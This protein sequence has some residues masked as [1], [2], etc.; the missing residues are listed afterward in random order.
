MESLTSITTAAAAEAAG[1]RS[2]EQHV[3]PAAE[4]E[5]E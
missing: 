1:V 4:D 2:I 3:R 5:G